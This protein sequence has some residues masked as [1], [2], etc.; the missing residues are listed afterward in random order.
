MLSTKTYNTPMEAQLI[1]PL[2]TD[3]GIIDA[4]RVSFDKEANNYDK[5]RN[6][7]LLGYL[8]RNRHWAPYAHA[9]EAFGLGI[10]PSDWLHFLEHAILAGFT[11]GRAGFG[12]DIILNG[13]LWAW[14][15]NLH[16]LPFPI[17]SK[18]VTELSKRYPEA[19]RIL[20][21]ETQ[22][23]TIPKNVSTSNLGYAEHFEFPDNSAVDFPQLAYVSF[24]ITAPIFIARQLVKHQVGLIWNEVSRRYVDD[25]PNLWVPGYFRSRVDN[26]KQGSGDEPA[27]LTPQQIDT[28]EGI[29]YQA[30]LMYDRLIELG[31][32]PE[33]ARIGLPLNMQTSWIWTG[34]LLAFKR[35]CK[36]RLDEHAQKYTRELV[37]LMY[38]Q[39]VERYPQAWNKI[40]SEG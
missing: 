30:L 4:A 40:W 10:E 35:I 1:N 24:R 27:A 25:A 19:G 36:E 22:Q 8:K 3:D 26:V 2:N 39:L 37:S 7:K 18:V 32:A 21:G 31:V 33:D 13:S 14:Y 15:E 23:Y 29:Q 17:Q 34:H 28:W 9:R 12:H 5:E 38:P 20:W 6:T 16:Y 11:W